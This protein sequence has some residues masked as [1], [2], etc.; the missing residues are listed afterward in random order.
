MSIE[1]MALG[2]GIFFLVMAIVRGGFAIREI[3]MPKVPNWAWLAPGVFG[4]LLLLPFLLA[5][6]RGEVD[7]DPSARTAAGV[8][9]S[10]AMSSSE[11]NRDRHRARDH[12]RSGQAD[13]AFGVCAERSTAGGGS[14][15][16]PF[17][18][19]ERSFSTTREREPF[20]S[21]GDFVVL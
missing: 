18:L 5:M 14:R 4:D 2:G 15:G 9:R 16:K 13:R 17:R 10:A 11:R 7:E 1:V 6:I 3:S 12:R 20:S 8:G 19:R 21:G